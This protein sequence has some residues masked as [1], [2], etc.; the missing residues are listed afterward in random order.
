MFNRLHCGSPV[1]TEC[2]ANCSVWLRY[3][4]VFSKMHCDSAVDTACLSNGSVCCSSGHYRHSYP[5]QVT[6]VPA[7]LNNS[8]TR[9]LLLA[10]P[11]SIDSVWTSPHATH[12]QATW[13]GS[14][15]LLATSNL[16]RPGSAMLSGYN[17]V[18]HYVL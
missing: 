14:E 8:A 5:L 16:C 18:I 13:H 3:G 9:S 7:I 15:R 6:P 11:H 17:C 10:P 4:H 12:R 1:D 2:L